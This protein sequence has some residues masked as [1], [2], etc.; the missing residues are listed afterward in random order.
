MKSKLNNQKGFTLIE[1][2]VVMVIIALLAAVAVPKFLDLQKQAEVSAV[3]GVVGNI[4]SA[5]SLRVA[6]ALVDGEDLATLAG[7]LYP[8]DLLANIPETY[9]GRGGTVP[10]E[11][12]VWY[13][14]DGSHDLYYIMKNT[15][16]VSDPT[17]AA[18]LRYEIEVV[19]ETINSV[20]TDV[21]LVFEKYD[22]TTTIDN[23]TIDDADFDWQY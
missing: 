17:D 20:V 5:L 23:S 10:T 8:M 2:V 12:G 4:R 3:K 22:D 21:G 14:G 9:N 1:L 15:D 18:Y 19:Q 13:E 7:S 11:K 6:R 16:I